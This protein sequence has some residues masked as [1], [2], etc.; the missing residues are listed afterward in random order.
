MS[1]VADADAV[2]GGQAP[3]QSVGASRAK[4]IHTRSKKITRIRHKETRVRRVVALERGGSV[5]MSSPLP[6]RIG[7]VPSL[8]HADTH[9]HTRTHPTGNKGGRAHVKLTKNALPVAKQLVL[10]PEVPHIRD[11]LI[12]SHLWWQPGDSRLFVPREH[13]ELEHTGACGVRFLP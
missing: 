12:H 2:P 3:A 5:H 6:H 11:V 13:A 1:L 7:L 4:P 10:V 8:T 9:M